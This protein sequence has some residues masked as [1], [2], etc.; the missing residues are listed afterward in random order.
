MA[1]WNRGDGGVVE[2][3]QSLRNR[4]SLAQL[5]T[6]SITSTFVFFLVFLLYV[7][8]IQSSYL[9]L[10]T[11]PSTKASASQSIISQ[12]RRITILGFHSPTRHC[13][14]RSKD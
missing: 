4:C 1:S 6:F 7:I 5:V 9:P 2:M 12:S 3:N 14:G 8:I 10:Y 11:T 13:D